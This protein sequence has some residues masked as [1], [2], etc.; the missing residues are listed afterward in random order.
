MFFLFDA[1]LSQ[2]NQIG[3]MIDSA[4]NI[5]RQF[6]PTYT[7]TVSIDEQKEQLKQPNCLVGSALFLGPT[8]RLMC[9]Q[10]YGTA[11]YKQFVRDPRPEYD[12]KEFVH[13]SGFKGTAVEAMKKYNKVRKQYS[14]A[15]QLSARALEKKFTSK[16]NA[17]RNKYQ[18]ET[19]SVDEESRGMVY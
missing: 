6:A 16:Y 12:G 8:I 11:T 15:K 5:I 1:S 3:D 13:G 7:K 18:S 9:S 4:T 17:I 19:A 10:Q 14:D 2:N